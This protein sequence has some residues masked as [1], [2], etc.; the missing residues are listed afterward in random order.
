MVA[1]GKRT[2]EPQSHLGE[3]GELQVVRDGVLADL[4]VE[5]Q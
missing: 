2:L 1:G 5:P 4:A 3:K